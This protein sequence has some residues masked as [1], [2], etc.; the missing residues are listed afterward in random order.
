MLFDIG[1][2]AWNLDRWKG[3]FW[4]VSNIGIPF[5]DREANDAVIFGSLT[6]WFLKEVQ[7][8]NLEFLNPLVLSARQKNFGM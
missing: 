8:L 6:A 4:D 7:F 2:A 1:S 3:E 5:H